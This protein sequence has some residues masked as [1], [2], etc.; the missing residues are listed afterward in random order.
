MNKNNGVSSASR[1]A[2]GK[3]EHFYKDSSK[4]VLSTDMLRTTVNAA[5]SAAVRAAANAAVSAAAIAA[6]AITCKGSLTTQ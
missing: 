2:K 3:E 1:K 5:V 6:V 4:D